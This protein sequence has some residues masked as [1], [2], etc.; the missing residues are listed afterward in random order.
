M[1]ICFIFYFNINLTYINLIFCIKIAEIKNIPV[2]E[3]LRI[4]TENAKKIYE[5]I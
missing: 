4:T 3:V 2:E 5:I 1:L